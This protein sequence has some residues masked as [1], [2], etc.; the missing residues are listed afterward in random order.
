M[1]KSM[2]EMLKQALDRLVKAET[3]I[4]K[5]KPYER[6]REKL[7]ILAEMIREQIKNENSHSSAR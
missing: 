5:T 4:H 6:E 3:H 1:S 2:E 7:R